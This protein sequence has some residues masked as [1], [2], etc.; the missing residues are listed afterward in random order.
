MIRGKTWN[1]GGIADEAR[2][3]ARSSELADGSLL[4]SMRNYLYREQKQRAFAVS[5]DGGLTLVQ[6]AAIARTSLPH[7]PVEHPAAHA[8]QAGGKTRILY[9]GPGG[10]GRKNMTIRLSYDEGKTW[11]VAKVLYAG[12]AAY[13]D[14]VV[15]PDGG[16]GCLYERDEYR[17]ITF[18]RFTLGWLTDGK[19][20]P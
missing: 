11:P 14:L 6:A 9:S 10:P 16:I 4:L 3:S 15:L 5:S 19:D 17:K 1:L 20:Q 7:L 8:C 12:S 2:T 13:S 18:A